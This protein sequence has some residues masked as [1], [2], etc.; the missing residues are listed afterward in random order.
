MR[1]YN[2]IC[3]QNDSRLQ[4][5]SCGH[6]AFLTSLHLVLG[7][8]LPREIKENSI[9]RR[10]ML[11]L[12]NT[13][14]TWLLYGIPPDLWLID[15]L[16]TSIVNCQPIPLKY[17]NIFGGPWWASSLETIGEHIIIGFNMVLSISFHLQI[18]Y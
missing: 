17:S 1:L 11:N 13:H 9:S 4:L 2:R 7:S 5:W 10:Q 8:K 14:L 18:I 6:F 3:I 15:C 16:N 12:Q